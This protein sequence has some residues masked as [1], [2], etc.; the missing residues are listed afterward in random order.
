MGSVT[1]LAI[2]RAEGTVVVVVAAGDPT[3][4][5]G[6]LRRAGVRR[7]DLLVADGTGPGV[8]GV[9]AAVLDRHPVGLIVGPAKLDVAGLQPIDPDH[10]VRAGPLAVTLDATGHPVVHPTTG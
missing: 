6:G 1:G 2:H 3:R 10:P 5:L 7:I 8:L 9:L 4:V